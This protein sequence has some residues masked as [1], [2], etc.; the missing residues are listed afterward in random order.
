MNTV[1]DPVVVQLGLGGGYAWFALEPNRGD[2]PLN[3]ADRP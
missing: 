2:Q 3:S 1:A